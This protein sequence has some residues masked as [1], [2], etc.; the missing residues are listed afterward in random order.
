MYHQQ[1]FGSKYPAQDL[2][3]PSQPLLRCNG[4]FLWELLRNPS[5]KSI[6]KE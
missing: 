1:V 5:M 4:W 6:S 3:P 2:S